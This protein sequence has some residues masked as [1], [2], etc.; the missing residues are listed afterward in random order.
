M[1]AV[2]SI[3]FPFVAGMLGAVIAAIR[4]GLWPPSSSDRTP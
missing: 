4:M 2:N 1:N 3:L